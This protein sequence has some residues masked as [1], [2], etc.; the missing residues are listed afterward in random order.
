MS[1]AALGHFGLK[2]ETTYGVEAT[3]PT[4]FHEIKSESIAADN[5]LII[6]RY[7]GGVKGN[8]RVLP[9]SYTAEGSF[10]LDAT[11]EDAMGWI[12]KGM[13]GS[14]VSTL[15]TT[16]VY[17]HLFT[18]GQSNDLP[19]FTIQV[20][21]EAGCRNWRGC[22]FSSLDITMSPDELI[23]MVVGVIAQYDNEATAAT[24]TYSTLDP[25]TAYDVAVT[26]NGVANT[27]MENLKLT[28][29][30]DVEGIKTL[31]NQ[32]WIGRTTAKNLNVAG[33][34]SMEF[35]DMDMLRRFWGSSVATQPLKCLDDSV[36]QIDIVSSCQQIGSTGHYYTL[37][38]AI[39]SFYIATG[40]PNLT[41][42]DDRVMQEIA[43]VTKHDSVTGKSISFTLK[44]TQSG[45]PDP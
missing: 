14:A 42:A 11:P 10:E 23:A 2:Q 35:N 3:P 36:L 33:S 18:P 29:S 30:N 39:P 19:S 43:F 21:A 9:G 7:I 32:R 44:N 37:S 24:P 22:Q 28:F 45:Y 1:G 25:F 5:N 31:N 20:D 41:G 34:F 6:P 26:L 12:L 16:G 38:I 15:V 4:V 27:A 40:A 13:C 17:S 8:K